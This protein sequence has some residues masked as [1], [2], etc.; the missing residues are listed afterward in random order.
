MG[1]NFRIVE[2]PP[3]RLEVHTKN[4]VE[5]ALSYRVYVCDNGTG[6]GGSFR[7]VVFGEISHLSTVICNG[8]VVI[9]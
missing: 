5:I 6:G 3:L 1:F 7:K 9:A 2:A 8:V 4:R